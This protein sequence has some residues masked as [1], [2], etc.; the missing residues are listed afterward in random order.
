MVDHVQVVDELRAI[1]TGDVAAEQALLHEE[2]VVALAL[3]AGE[4]L[5]REG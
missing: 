1:A 5:Q 4:H 3:L 2:G